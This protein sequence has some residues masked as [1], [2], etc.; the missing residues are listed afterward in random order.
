MSR[1]RFGRALAG[2]GAVLLTALA[3]SAITLPGLAAPAFAGSAA[4]GE[5]P[6][7]DACSFTDERIDESSGLA[8]GSDVLFTVNDS[9]DDALVYAVDKLTCG[10]VAATA[11]SSEEVV[12]V[13]ALAADREGRLWVGDI[14]DNLGTRGW[15][16]VYRFP[17]EQVGQSSVEAERFSLAYPDGPHD[18]EALLVHPGTG[19]LY[20]VT[21]QIFG[22]GVYAAPSEL[23]PD[24]VNRLVLHK[25][26]DVGRVTDG[27]FFPDG[28]QMVLRGY[29]DA[30]VYGFPGFE[31]AAHL[32]LPEQ[33]QGEAITVSRT[34][35]VYLS[36]EGVNAPVLELFLPASFEGSAPAASPRAAS[37]SATSRQPAQATAD[38]DAD[39]L[40]AL[41]AMVVVA[42][43]ACYGLFTVFR[44]HGRRRR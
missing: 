25:R 44:P 23:D 32:E 2:I 33:E 5:V 43:F 26:L 35:Q 40:L 42:V 9:G 4:A 11:Y 24:G 21:K 37:P 8:D 22:A 36:S 29:D 7:R 16:D 17:A 15:V 10:T 38:E 41:S 14:G 12:D 18:A 28:R 3:G 20:V 6:F 1:A 13:E 39:S 31:E 19:R 30:T 34:G 27:A